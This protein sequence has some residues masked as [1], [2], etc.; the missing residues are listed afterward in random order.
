VTKVVDGVIIRIEHGV[1]NDCWVE[2]GLVM[3]ICTY[4]YK[5]L[6]QIRPRS[7]QSIIGTSTY[8]FFNFLIAST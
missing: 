1:L 8:V 7:R 4:M 5:A 3:Y 6:V 2:Q